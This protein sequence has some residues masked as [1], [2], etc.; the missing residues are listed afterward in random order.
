MFIK[1]PIILPTERNRW[2]EDVKNGIEMA[3]ANCQS[4]LKALPVYYHLVNNNHQTI[5]ENLD[6][7]SPIVIAAVGTGDYN[8]LKSHM[9]DRKFILFTPTASK[10]DLL[11]NCKKCFRNVPSNKEEAKYMT[12]FLLKQQEISVSD[13]VI[14]KTDNGPYSNSFAQLLR[15]N[16]TGATVAWIP[17]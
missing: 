14:F 11:N 15:N 2:I 13:I 17:T 8:T 5:I 6:G 9:N 1:I 7:E 12:D 10:A 16:L 3:F 4:Q